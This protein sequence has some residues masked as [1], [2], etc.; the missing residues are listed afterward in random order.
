MQELRS[1][2]KKKIPY[3]HCSSCGSKYI[4]SKWPKACS[5]CDTVV[6]R[7]PIPV[8]VGLIPICDNNKTGILL[9]RRA[10]KPSVGELCLP[11]GFVDW[12]ES[13]RT[14]LSR[15]IFEETTLIT[16]PDEFRLMDTCSIPDNSRILIFGRSI[17]I[18]HIDE[19]KNFKPNT[20]VSALKLGLSKDV[21][22][23][24]LHQKAFNSWFNE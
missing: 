1:V 17:K 19:L 2:F 20:E 14:G 8:V 23:F 18:R 6:F 16:E 3:S 7:N 5:C 12:G 4:Y 21:L 24:S 9:I 15:E 13:W 11:G 10:I 22:C